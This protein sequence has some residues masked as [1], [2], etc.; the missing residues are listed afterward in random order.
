L[1]QGEPSDALQR[2]NARLREELASVLESSSWRL[3]RPLRRLRGSKRPETLVHVSVPAEV[4]TWVDPALP[5]TPVPLH[6]PP[7]HY[8]SPIADP[9]ELV[10]EPRR[11]QIWPVSARETPGVDWRHAEQVA[12]CRDVFAR[13]TRLALRDDASDDPSEYFATN[14]QYPPLDA[15]LLEAMLQRQRPKRFIEIGSGFSSLVTARVNR[16]L[17]DNGMRFTCVEPYPRQFLLDGVPG[18]SDLI[19]EKVQDVALETFETLGSGDILFVDTSHT[20]KTGGDVTWIFH[21]IIPRLAPGVLVHV[22]DAFLP[23]DYPETWVREGWGWNEAYL[24]HSFLAFNSGFE[25]EIGVRY[26]FYRQPEALA[27]AFP[28]WRTALNQGGAALW[29]RRRR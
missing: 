12:L 29:F 4:A 8:Y 23:G 28:D 10:V 6:V 25:I 5:T 16:E 17:L 19:V 27:E 20:V 2:E 1:S 18:I 24:L 14:G 22:H 3:T 15:W 21:E 13:Q 9:S 26:L 11:S 7:G